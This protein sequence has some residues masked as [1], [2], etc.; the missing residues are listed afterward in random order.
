MAGSEAFTCGYEHWLLL[1]IDYQAWAEGF[2]APQE[3]NN[4]VVFRP[5][6]EGVV[7]GMEDHDAPALVQIV[8]EI[9]LDGLRPADAVF[10]MAAVEVVDY[11]LIAL[12]FGVPVCC[13]GRDG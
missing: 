5:F 1:D 4:L 8:E 13:G 2:V 11:Y 9:L 10:E 12:E 7:G 6:E 3:P